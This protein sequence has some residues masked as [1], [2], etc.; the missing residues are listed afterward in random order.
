MFRPLCTFLAFV[1]AL[2]VAQQSTVD[3]MWWG[4]HNRVVFKGLPTAEYEWT[5]GQTVAIK[6]RFRRF[7]RRSQAFGIRIDNHFM[8]EIKLANADI[9]KQVDNEGFYTAVFKLPPGL[10]SSETYTLK[11]VTHGLLR[12]GLFDNTLAES[13]EF[14]ISSKSATEKHLK[15]M[16]KEAADKIEEAAKKA[17]EEAEKAAKEAAKNAPSTVI[18]IFVDTNKP[19][20]QPA[21]NITAFV[22]NAEANAPQGKFFDLW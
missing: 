4:E 2:L 11:L 20:A 17:K 6:F 12:T 8:R 19:A 16:A 9:S 10:R 7:R 15:K 21:F 18:P 14:P 13:Q 5:A 3:A 22:P 1:M